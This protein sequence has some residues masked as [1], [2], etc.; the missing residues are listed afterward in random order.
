VERIL[1]AGILK[2]K[3]EGSFFFKEEGEG[4]GLFQKRKKGRNG[5]NYKCLRC[6]QRIKPAIYPLNKA[7]DML[8]NQL[9]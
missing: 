4:R 3:E 5:E 7:R 9:H 2:G 8:T 6:W 1:V